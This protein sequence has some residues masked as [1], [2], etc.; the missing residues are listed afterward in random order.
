MYINKNVNNKLIPTIITKIKLQNVT[1]LA[2]QNLSTYI[3]M[4]VLKN[5]G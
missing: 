3:S 5:I 4:N 1:I 2:H